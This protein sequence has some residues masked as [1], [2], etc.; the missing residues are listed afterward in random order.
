MRVW[1]RIFSFA[2]TLPDDSTSGYGTAQKFYK[3][4]MA[5]GGAFLRA[6]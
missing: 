3:Q 6:I 1:W 5:V 2:M 4:N